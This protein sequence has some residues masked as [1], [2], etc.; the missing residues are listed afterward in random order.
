VA[1]TVDANRDDLRTRLLV[2]DKELFGEYDRLEA[3]SIFRLNIIP[4]LILPTILF[5]IRFF[6]FGRPWSWIVLLLPIALIAMFIQGMARYLDAQTV[7]MRAIVVDKISAPYLTESLG[8][9]SNDESSNVVK[10]AD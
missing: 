8:K 1:E 6:H 3:E 4:P 2:A 5:M 9:S 7:L 10:G